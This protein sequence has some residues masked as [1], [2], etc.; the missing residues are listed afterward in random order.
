MLKKIESYS[1]LYYSNV[2][3][4][5]AEI[6]KEKITKLKRL[7]DDCTDLYKKCRIKSN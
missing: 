6:N 1:L 5:S 7:S 2:F 4:K 3:K